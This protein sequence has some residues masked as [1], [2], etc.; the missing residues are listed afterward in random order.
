MGAFW[1]NG[2]RA[3]R[4]SRQRPEE[5]THLVALDRSIAKLEHQIQE[6]SWLIQDAREFRS[7]VGSVDP[8]KQAAPGAGPAPGRHRQRGRQR[9]QDASG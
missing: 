9:S 2:T 6:V 1:K 8:Q 5:V 4:P 7:D 3:K